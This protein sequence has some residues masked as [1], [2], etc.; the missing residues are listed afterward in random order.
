MTQTQLATEIN[1]WLQQMSGHM[2]Y[3][4]IVITCALCELI[5]HEAKKL[6]VKHYNL[7][8]PSQREGGR[9]GGI[10]IDTYLT[11]TDPQTLTEQCL[12]HVSV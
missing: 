4:K 2:F 1:N 8:G 5:P 6:S 3:I 9:D 11:H 10:Q 12:V 7:P